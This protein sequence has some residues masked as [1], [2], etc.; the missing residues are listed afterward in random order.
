M[1]SRLAFFIC[2]GISAALIVAGFIVPPTGIVD[3]SVLTGVGELL[4]FA[5]LSALFYAIDK[6]FGTTF[7]HGG[8]EVRI[9]NPDDNDGADE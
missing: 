6:G 1:K 8:T 7:K 9:D 5:T 2:L 4:G 3:G